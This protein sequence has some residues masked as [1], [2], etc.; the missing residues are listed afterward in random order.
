M[1]TEQE[2]LERRT[3]AREDVA[4]VFRAAA[5][6]DVPQVDGVL[7]GFTSEGKT[8][9]CAL[10]LFSHCFGGDP[11]VTVAVLRRAFNELVFYQCPVE[12]CTVRHHGEMILAHLNNQT[13]SNNRLVPGHGFDWLTI[14][15]Y[16]PLIEEAPRPER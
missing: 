11:V 2:Q 13:P 16:V 12:G 15:K 5:L 7:K 6:N 8:G 4:E 9:Y 10:G 14:A 1:L 3:K